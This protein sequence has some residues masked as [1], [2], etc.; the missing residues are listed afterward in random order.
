MV[1]ASIADELP[2]GE[3]TARRAFEEMLA[4]VRRLAHEAA[5][6]GLLSPELAAGI[7]RVKGAKTVGVRLGNW[8]SADEVKQ[9]HTVFARPRLHNY[10]YPTTYRS[11]M[12]GGHRG[13]VRQGWTHSNGAGT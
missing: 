1:I 12:S 5:D 9:L 4:A 13:S 2:S 10:P 11:A 8:L 3:A 6:T 7:S